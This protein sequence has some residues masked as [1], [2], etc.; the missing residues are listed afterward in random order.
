[1]EWTVIITIVAIL[2]VPLLGAAVVLAVRGYRMSLGARLVRCPADGAMVRTEVSPW[3]AAFNSALG[4]E[5]DVIRACT[6]WPERGECGQEC[7]HQIETSPTGCREEDLVA[8]W[9]DGRPCGVCG[10]RL[11][12][13]PQ[14]R[15]QVAYVDQEGL[16][17]QL[18]DLEG[19]DLV[20]LFWSC[21][22][23]CWDCHTSQ[24]AAA[25]LS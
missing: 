16:T 5:Q 6:H 23:V 13:T 15:D 12:T 2:A 7:M 22:P 9:R 24:A 17:A 18:H 21:E 14:A 20:R 1:M 3:R 25:G 19:E 11:E 8:R 4:T 10:A